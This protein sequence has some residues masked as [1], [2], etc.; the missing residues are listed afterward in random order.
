LP[1][2]KIRFIEPMYARLVQS[3]PHGQEWLYEVK[4]D[5]Y[6]CLAGRDST[7]V[8]LWSRRQ[9]LFTK[10][11]PRIAQACERL[12]PNTLIDGEIVA[13]DSSGRVSFNLLQHH[14]SKAHA[15]VF[16]AFDVLIYHGRSVL[17]VPLYFRRE[18][19]HRIFE[20][21]KTVPI[22]L[23]EN[24]EASPRDL[25]RVAK[26]FG[27]EGIVAKRK[28]SFYESGKPTGAWVKYKVNRGQ[29][30]VI[31]GYTPGSPFD[32][33]IVGYYEDGKLL[34]AAKVSNGFVPQVRREVASKFKGL[35]IDT[36]PFSNL[37]EKKRTQWALTKEEMKNCVWLSP[38][39]VAQ[40]EFTEWTPDGHLRHSKFVGLRTDKDPR[41]VVRQDRD[42]QLLLRC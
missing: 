42:D 35:E 2:A 29:E 33:L 34:Y 10:Q 1:P 18:V 37:P 23:S 26:E 24:I 14:R 11:F 30:F 5:G 15:L 12:P 20:D 27:F 40:I 31:G 19:L 16:Y 22:S 4:F 25:V 21:T 39:L 13:L 36:C 28:D 41:Q 6:R 7:G 9:N 17:D 32:A 8:T 3:L 38:Q